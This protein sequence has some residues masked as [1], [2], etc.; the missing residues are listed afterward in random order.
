MAP[1]WEEVREKLQ[2][3]DRLTVIEVPVEASQAL[4]RLTARHMKLQVTI[5]EE[6]VFIADDGAASIPV[7]IR[8]LKAPGPAR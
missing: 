7:T 2:R 1:W 8:L 6:H 5:Q 4:A 3:Q